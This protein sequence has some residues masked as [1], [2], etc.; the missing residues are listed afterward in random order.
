MLTDDVKIIV[1]TGVESSGKTTLAQDLSAHYR[2]P[3]VPE[4]ARAYLEARSGAYAFDDIEHIARLHMQSIHHAKQ[5]ANNFLFVD[6]ALLVLKI[7][8]EEKY[9]RCAPYILNSLATFAPTAYLL[10]TPDIP[11]EADA[12]REHPN[13]Q[14]RIRL[15]KT[16]L[17]HLQEEV[18]PFSLMAGTK[19]ERL[20]KAI[21]LIKGL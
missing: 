4:T 13:E 19:K 2:E 14:D 10:C 3:W 18:S 12:L 9:H 16:Y 5:D 11:W 8:S 1:V 6:T 15:H 20:E 17:A 7:W 21:Q